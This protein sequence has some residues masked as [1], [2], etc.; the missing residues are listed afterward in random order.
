MMVVGSKVASEQ[1]DMKDGYRVVINEGQQGC[2]SV[3]HLHI[4]F[5]GGQQLSWPPG[6]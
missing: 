5:I 6:V 1:E 2:Q 4:H 3:F